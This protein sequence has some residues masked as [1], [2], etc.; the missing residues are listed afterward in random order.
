MSLFLTFNCF[1][2][3]LGKGLHN[4]AIDAIKAALSNI[5]PSPSGS[6]NL[7]DITEIDAGNGYAS[8]GMAVTGLTYIEKPASSG[9]WNLSSDS[10]E[11]VAGGGP[12]GPFRYVVLYNN[13]SETKPLIGYL[14][15]GSSITLADGNGYLIHIPDDTGIMDVG[16]GTIP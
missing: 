12:I 4:F 7:A 3:D 16:A 6:T 10:V 8:G 14:D 2:G 9:I 1:P 15:F 13:T 11:F 5:P